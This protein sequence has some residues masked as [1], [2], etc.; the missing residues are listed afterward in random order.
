MV[1]VVLALLVAPAARL[2]MY[3]YPR[4]VSEVVLVESVER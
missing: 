2:E 4:R 1:T 3:R